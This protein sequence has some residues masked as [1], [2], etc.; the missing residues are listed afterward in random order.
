ML[1]LPAHD[2]SVVEGSR[3]A[4]ILGA[5]DHPVNSRHHQAVDHVGEGLIVS[6]RSCTDGVIEALEAPARR[7]TVAVQWHPRIRSI[8]SLR[9]GSSSSR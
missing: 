5:G 3:L 8:A 9:R 7:F 1:R 6:A 4:A 2:V